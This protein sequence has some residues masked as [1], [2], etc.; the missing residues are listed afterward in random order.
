MAPARLGTGTR[1]TAGAGRPALAAGQLIIVPSALARALASLIARIAVARASN[2]FTSFADNPLGAAARPS[3]TS[4]SSPYTI[5]R[6]RRCRPSPP[7]D[8]TTERSTSNALVYRPSGA[9]ASARI[10]VAET[11][12]RSGIAARRGSRLLIDRQRG[13]HLPLGFDI[14]GNTHQPVLIRLLLGAGRC[15]QQRLGRAPG[16]QKA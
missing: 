10:G 2:F 15:V 3:S 6:F 4:P 8:V 14:G 5:I 1:W 16:E 7:G 11:H 12:L 13:D 9:Y